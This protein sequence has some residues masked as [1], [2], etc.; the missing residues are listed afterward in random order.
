MTR[1]FVF[2]L[3]FFLSLVSC[4]SS[5]TN[6]AR[7]ADGCCDAVA[8]S[9]QVICRV[10]EFSFC[11]VRPELKKQMM[12]GP[13]RLHGVPEKYT[14]SSLLSPFCSS[15]NA[16]SPFYDDGFVDKVVSMYSDKVGF[17][18]KHSPCWRLRVL[19]TAVTDIDNLI[20]EVN[21]SYYYEGDGN[22]GSVRA[23]QRLPL[24]A[25]EVSACRTESGVPEAL[26]YCY[27]GDDSMPFSVL[28]VCFMLPDDNYYPL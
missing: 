18:R 26:F 27:Y 28:C 24:R 13:F 5:G 25:M 1:I 12:I 14:C 11:D 16:F 22:N 23:M 2:L 19:T 20:L 7:V 10:L 15:A 3:P 17:F 6:E 8:P 21:Y 4:T 9:R